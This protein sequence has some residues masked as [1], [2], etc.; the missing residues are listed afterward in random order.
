[1]LYYAHLLYVNNHYI[2]PHYKFQKSLFRTNNGFLDQPLTTSVEPH[3][4]L[5][6]QNLHRPLM[7]CL[8]L[9]QGIELFVVDLPELAV[10]S[11]RGVAKLVLLEKLNLTA[12]QTKGRVVGRIS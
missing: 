8:L 5:G 4:L 7:F 1:M 6:L 3:V 10:V 12:S 2:H 11:H 9:P